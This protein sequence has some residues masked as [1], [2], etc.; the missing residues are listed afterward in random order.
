M[1]DSPSSRPLLDRVTTRRA[2]LGAAVGAGS[3][4]AAYAAF[5]T[6]LFG[7]GSPSSTEEGVV[8][9]SSV[10]EKESARIDHLLRRAGFGA[11]A[12]ERER[13]QSLG[14]QATTDELVS[15]TTVNDDEALALAAQAP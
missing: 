12:G 5:G 1:P 4:A 8:P 13:Y 3:L 10:L 11:S 2:V 14:L 9:E 6:D 15:F 7:H